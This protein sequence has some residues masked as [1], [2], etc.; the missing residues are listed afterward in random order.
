MGTY[1]RVIQ[2]VKATIASAEF[3]ATLVQIYFP[4][5]N[6]KKLGDFHLLVLLSH[7]FGNQFIQINMIPIRNSADMSYKENAMMTLANININF[8]RSN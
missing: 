6:K 5:A 4:K 2:L 7:I 1:V 3:T 8:Q